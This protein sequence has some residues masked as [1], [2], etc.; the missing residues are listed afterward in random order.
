VRT[1]ASIVAE[2][3]LLHVRTAANET[4]TVTHRLHAIEARLDPR[5]FIRLSR[6]TL[7]NVEMIA[8]ISPMPGGTFVA[9][10]SNG[11][12]LSVSRNQSRTLRETILKL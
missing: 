2:G 5:R 7:V 1:I 12:A 10:L 9:T 8:E 3:E 4:Y 6:G 11:E